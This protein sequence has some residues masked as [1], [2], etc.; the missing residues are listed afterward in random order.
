MSEAW[1]IFPNKIRKSGLTIYDSIVIGSELWIPAAELQAI[2]N[3]ALRGLNLTGLPLRTRSKRVKERVA[4]ALGYPIPSTFLI[5]QPRF[6]GQC[7]DTYIQ[8]SNNLQVWN[9]K[10]S[11]LRRYVII[12]VDGN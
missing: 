1:E 5:T 9:E 10:L 6:P 3:R 11:A 8:K 2:L 7:F 4:E 12:R